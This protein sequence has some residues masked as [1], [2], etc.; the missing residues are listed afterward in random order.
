MHGHHPSFEVAL[1]VLI[2]ERMVEL[3]ILVVDN[4]LAEHNQL[5]GSPI[6]HPAFI[7]M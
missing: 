2:Q 6:L 5:C 4:S 3:T 7:G 1:V